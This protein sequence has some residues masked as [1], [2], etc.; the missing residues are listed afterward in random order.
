MRQVFETDVST[1]EFF[2]KS[3]VLLH[4][5]C[6]P[7]SRNVVERQHHVDA[8]QQRW[9]RFVVSAAHVHELF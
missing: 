3:L 1:L 9:L 8:I 7:S 2:E 6:V 5:G 4:T